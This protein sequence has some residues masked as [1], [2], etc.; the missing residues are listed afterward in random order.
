[1][2][3]RNPDARKSGETEVELSEDTLCECLRTGDP[4]DCA[5]V[6]GQW[7]TLPLSARTEAMVRLRAEPPTQ[8]QQILLNHLVPD[9]QPG[10]MPELLDLLGSDNAGLRNQVIDALAQVQGDDLREQLCQLLRERLQS[11]DTDVRIL[12]LNLIAGLEWPDLLPDVEQVMAR[13]SEVNVC[14]TALDAV[15]VLGDEKQR[16]AVEALGHRFPDEPFVAF[17]VE[18]ARAK[19]Q[20]GG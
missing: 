1:M 4:D 6:L 13:D 14:M 12:T 15:L 18:Q 2:L 5:H 19:L 3:I 10:E 16:S 8:L 20:E 17:S 11:E 9:L 7:E